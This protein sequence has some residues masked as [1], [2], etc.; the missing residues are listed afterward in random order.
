MTHDIDKNKCNTKFEEQYNKEKALITWI[1]A[2]K[3][4]IL[5]SG[6]KIA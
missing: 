2:N 1:K 6:I 3:L 5:N 4:K